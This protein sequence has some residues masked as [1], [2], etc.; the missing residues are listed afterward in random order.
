MRITC[1]SASESETRA[2]GTALADLLLPDGVLRLDGDLGA[3]KTVLTQ[4]L[5]KGIGISPAEVQSPTFTLIREHHGEKGILV[6]IDLYRLAGEELEALGL[7]ELLAGPGVKAVEWSERL[8]FPVPEAISVRLRL[9]ETAHDR[10]L[11]V[12]STEQQD[13]IHRALGSFSARL[14]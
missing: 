2:I 8:S 1:C 14:T 3:G 13:E 4:G 10:E 7:W 5:A 6:H 12:E 9:G 11:E